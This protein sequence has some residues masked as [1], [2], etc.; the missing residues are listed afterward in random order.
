MKYLTQ[1]IP[2]ADSDGLFEFYIIDTEKDTKERISGTKEFVD[3]MK[4][5]KENSL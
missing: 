1:T 3:M 4:K 5:L 2:V